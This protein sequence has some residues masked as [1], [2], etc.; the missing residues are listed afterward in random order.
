MPIRINL[1]AEALAEEDLRRRDPV[2]R[3]I[4]GGAFLVVLSLVWFSS[5]W[6]EY[7]VDKQ[8]L[9]HIEAEIQVHT[10]DYAHVQ[11]NLKKIGDI[12][13]RLDSLDQLT[14]TRFL[15]GN[16]MNGL[17]ET[18]VPNIQLTRVFVEQSTGVRPATPA[19]TNSVG[20]IPGQPA[21]IAEHIALKLEA[22]DFAMNPDQVQRFKDALLNQS[23]FKNY[24][25]SDSAIRLLTL[26]SSESG[27]GDAKPF[28]RFSLECHFTDRP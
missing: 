12:R 17:Q 5:T 22:K 6:L 26:G 8:K 23:Y 24:I 18:Y 14:R 9:N 11:S 10:N 3:A 25:E 13:M 27:S 16:L 2:K 4:Y 1:L 28:V 7:V 21:G 19:R 15:Q 20:V